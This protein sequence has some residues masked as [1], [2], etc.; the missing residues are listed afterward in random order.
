MYATDFVFD[1][2]R[3]SSLGLMICSFDGESETA[4]GG[5]IDYSVVK[6]PGRDQFSFYGAQFS[7]VLEWNFSICKNPCLCDTP[8]FSRH[9]ESTVAKWLLKTNGY[10]LLQFDQPGYEDIFYRACIRPVPRQ[11]AGRTVGFDLTAVADCAYGF[12]D[13]IRRTAAIK[14][15]QPFRLDIHSDVDTYIL[16]CAAITCRGPF[17]LFNHRDAAKKDSILRAPVQYTGKS[18]SFTMDSDT[19]TVTGLDNPE[20]IN[21]HFL[22]LADGINYISTDSSL[23]LT[24][25]LAYREPRLVRI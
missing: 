18:R 16:P 25:E 17:T 15:G 9:E 21:W 2:Q 19:D 14:A 20:L 6:S 12:S 22:R 1:N 23:S 13:I 7:S 10:R 3:A 24:I 4:S 5:E 8:Y 11:S